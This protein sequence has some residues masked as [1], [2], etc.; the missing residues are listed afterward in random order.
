[1]EKS[2]NSTSSEQWL[3]ELIKS[4]AVQLRTM[5]Q[6]LPELESYLGRLSWMNSHS[7]LT[8]LE[9]KLNWLDGDLKHLN[10]SIQSLNR[11]CKQNQ[12]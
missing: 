7:S 4:V 6:E 5:T 8:G 3:K 11:Y 12:V 9:E 2:L 1:M 10:T